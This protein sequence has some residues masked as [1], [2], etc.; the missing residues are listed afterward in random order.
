MSATMTDPDTEA[1]DCLIRALTDLLRDPGLAHLELAAQ[2][3]GSVGI[4][5][6]AGWRRYALSGVD[7]DDNVLDRMAQLDQ[8]QWPAL[9]TDAGEFVLGDAD[10]ERFRGPDAA[11][12]VA[13]LAE[14]LQAAPYTRPV[15]LM[16]STVAPDGFGIELSYVDAV[17][18]DEG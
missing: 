11:L 9:T 8:A 18:T 12:L 6:Q 15:M 4:R 14:L 2:A 16:S 5:P 17:P 10:G 3:D 13:A 1:D 7:E